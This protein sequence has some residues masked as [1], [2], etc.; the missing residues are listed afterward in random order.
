MCHFVV[1]SPFQMGEGEVTTALNLLMLWELGLNLH[2][3]MG[4]ADA[5]GTIQA[6]YFTGSRDVIFK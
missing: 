5:L 3:F 2:H 4:N 6:S 1:E